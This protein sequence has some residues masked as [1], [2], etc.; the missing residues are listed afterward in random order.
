MTEPGLDQA[1]VQAVLQEVQ[2]IRQEILD[3]ISRIF[4]LHTASLTFYGAI[5]GFVFHQKEPQAFLLGPVIAWAVTVLWLRYKKHLDASSYYLQEIEKVK[6]VELIG[7]RDDEKEYSGINEYKKYWVAWQ[8]Y[9]DRRDT[10]PSIFV[11]ALV[12]IAIWFFGLVCLYL[13]FTLLPN[14]K[15]PDIQI[16]LSIVGAILLL[17]SGIMIIFKV[18]EKDSDLRRQK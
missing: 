11:G 18:F 8:H 10:Q 14:P 7:F 2:F 4:K 1:R 3:N 9:H 13:G 16:L 12:V 17:W 5:I 15:S 6:W